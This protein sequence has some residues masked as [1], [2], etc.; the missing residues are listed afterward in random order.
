MKRALIAVTL[1][2]LLLF[3]A[4]HAA[5][6]Q[7]DA[8][9]PHDTAALAVMSFNI[10]YNNPG[11]S[12]DAWPERSQDVAT[13]IR[14]HAPDVVGLQEALRGQLVDLAHAL[15]EYAWIGEGRS[16]EERGNEYSAILYRRDR[17]RVVESGTFWLSETP[18]TPY[19]RG[20]D[21]ALERI[22]TWARFEVLGSE[23]ELG[24]DGGP[25]GD[26]AAASTSKRLVHLNT[27]FDHRGEQ[28]RL[29]SARLIAAWTRANAGGDP[30]VVTG[31]LN[32][33]PGSAPIA[34]LSGA[35]L[36][37]A[38]T[39]TATPHHGP[40]GTWNGFRA[41]DIERRIDYIFIDARVRVEKHAI[42]PGIRPNGRFASDHLPVLAHIRF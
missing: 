33:L 24:S 16:R 37:D 31:D 7:R 17:L 42:L 1:V 23:A 39:A 29:E 2:A 3:L 21:A 41:I 12:L 27:H 26:P 40:T 30:V 22:A 6:A 34:A 13:L 28:A 10:R 20:W 19:S 38:F 9:A 11:D 25:G 4:A 8:Q 35:G 5:S 32:T 36:H 14:Y 15:P 18:E